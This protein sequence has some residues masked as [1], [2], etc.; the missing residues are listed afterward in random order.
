MR[1]DGAPNRNRVLIISYLFPPAGGIAV[2]RSLSLSKYL[3]ESGHEV[4]VLKANTDGPV[5]DPDLT[6]R[7]PP[8]VHVHEAF[9]PEIP[10]AFRHK[11]WSKLS[12]SRPGSTAGF[13]VKPSRFSVRRL[14][15]RWIKNLLCPEPE[16]LWIPFGLRK[17]RNI[18]RQHRI[19]YLLVT[20]PPFSLLV[21]ATALKR[22]FPSITL[23]SDF[24]DEWLS[25]YLKDFEFQNSDRTRRRAEAI[26]KDVVQ[27]SD[28]VVAVNHSSCNVIRSRYP[29]QPDGKFAVVANGYDRDTF[30]GFKARPHGLPRMIVTHAGTV[31]KT[32]TPKFYLDAVDSLTQD[33]RANIETRFIGRISEG[34]KASLESRASL[35]RVAGFLPQT[36]ALKFMEETDY[37]LLTMTNEIS[38]PGK[39]Y[40]YMATG[41]PILAITPAGSEVDRVLRETCCGLSAPPDD[42]EGIK[43]MLRLAFAAWRKGEPLIVPRADLIRRYDRRRLVTE[44]D[45]IMQAVRRAGVRQDECV[46]D[47]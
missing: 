19:E 34:E 37:L 25:F 43:A 20:V 1:Q 9:A 33:L 47:N 14:I 38:V 3:A 13:P 21:L 15:V 39:L 41:K 7:I 4:H 8:S 46:A 30:A 12:S 29:D 36:E 27:S 40:E 42:P 24:R 32:A 6:R 31:Y 22:Q 28:L 17:A 35:V 2:Q 11:V 10:F 5:S 18:I 45:N 26:E 44:Y 16:I 23:V